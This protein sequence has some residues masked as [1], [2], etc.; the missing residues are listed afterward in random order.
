MK[1]NFHIC[2]KI[3]LQPYYVKK[4][5]PYDLYRRVKASIN[6]FSNEHNAIQTNYIYNLS[7]TPTIERP[8]DRP[9]ELPPPIITLYDNSTLEQGTTD[10]G[11]PVGSSARIRTKD[12]I[13]VSADKLYNIT[14]N[15]SVF[16]HVDIWI[17]YFKDDYTWFSY[18]NWTT[19]TSSMD[20]SPPEGTKYI[21]IIICRNR[22]D[23]IV[24][25]NIDNYILREITDGTSQ[26]YEQIN[27]TLYTG[28]NLYTLS[29]TEEIDPNP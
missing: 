19:T 26:Y 14:V 28:N 9:E 4:I 8:S 2:K 24:P 22:E 23:P 21:K 1:I 7:P 25:S 20:F 16:R 17:D 27:E 5:F 12:Y 29:K 10:S 13:Q 18:K 11:V 6:H 15:Q 3:N